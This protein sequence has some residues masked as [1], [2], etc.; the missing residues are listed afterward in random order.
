VVKLLRGSDLE[1]HR[2]AACA[3]AAFLSHEY[4]ISSVIAGGAAGSPSMNSLQAVMVAQLLESKALPGFA[5]RAGA[6]TVAAKIAAAGAIPLLCAM[7][8]SPAFEPTHY[9]T[10]AVAALARTSRK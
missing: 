7:L 3:L 1:H 5:P 2:I 9:G 6:V 4:S 8:R 10:M